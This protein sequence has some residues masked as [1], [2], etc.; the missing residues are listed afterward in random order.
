VA[1][2][3]L[4]WHILER[5]FRSFRQAS[6]PLV[7][8]IG[9]ARQAFRVPL[10]KPN[11]D[12]FLASHTPPKLLRAGLYAGVSTNDQQILA[13]QNRAMGSMPPGRGRTIAM[14]IGSYNT[15]VPS[16]TRK[17]F[18]GIAAGSLSLD[19]HAAPQPQRRPKNVLLVRRGHHPRQ[20]WAPVFRWRRT[21]RNVDRCQTQEPIAPREF[22]C[23]V[24][25]G[26]Y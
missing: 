16:F 12:M 19:L 17:E 1:A 14:A 3:V 23:Y 8:S 25:G 22:G 4:R 20:A 10:R 15:V 2:S 21:L 11:R 9:D 5:A 18:L 26:G 7:E 13:M 24:L 6:A